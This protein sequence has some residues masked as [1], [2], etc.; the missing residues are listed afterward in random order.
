M[1]DQDRR[2]IYRA[3]ADL[4]TQSIDQ[5]FLSTLGPGFL[6]LLYGAIDESPE[7]ALIVAYED[8]A[9]CGFIAGTVNLK[10]V[11]LGLL[12]RWP[13]LVVALAPSLVIPSRLWRIVEILHYSRGTGAD[14]VSLPEAELLSLAVSPSCRGRGHA[15]ALYAGLVDFFADRN[16]AAFKIVVG[17]ELARAHRFYRRMGAEPGAEITVHRGAASTVYVQNCGVGDVG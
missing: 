13:A 9:V 3:V 11:Y 14:A 10:Q 7:S 4:H 16:Q 1:S 17:A 6:S 2:A 5:G 15:E 8:G 12:R